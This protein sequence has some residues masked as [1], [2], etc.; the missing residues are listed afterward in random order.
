MKEDIYLLYK[1]TFPNN[2]AYIGITKRK[3]EIRYGQ[4][5]Y[6]YKPNKRMWDDIQKYGW[7][8]IKHEIIY[9]NKTREEISELEREEIKNI[10]QIILISD[11]IYKLEEYTVRVLYM[12]KMKLFFFMKKV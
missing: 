5:G 8:N 4:N 9:M 12:M 10:N 6:H 2:K 1:H 3:P 7:D 11:I